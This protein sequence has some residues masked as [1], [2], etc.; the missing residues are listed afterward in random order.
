MPD[1]ASRSRS[2][3]EREPGLSRSSWNFYLKAVS[4]G[5]QRS[6]R[7]FFRWRGPRH[8][9]GVRILFL[10][11]Y[12][13]PETGAPQNRISDWAVRLAARGHEITVLTAMPNYPGGKIFQEYRGRVLCEERRDGI[14]VLRTWIYA[15]QSKDFIPRL[16]NYFSF[17]VSSVLLGIFKT[18]RQDVI[19]VES[20]PLFTGISGLVL[21]VLLR[22]KLVFN[23]SDLWPESAVALGVLKNRLL[24][25]L[26]TW[27]ENLLYRKSALIT[28]QTNGIV[29]KIATRF[30]QKQV[31]LITN[32]IDT[33]FFKS[34]SVERARDARQ[35]VN[36]N[37]GFVVGYAGL[38]GLAQ[39]LETVLDAANQLKQ[40]SDISFAFFGDGP[41]K[42][43]LERLACDMALDNVRFYPNQSRSMVP[44][45]LA[46]FDASV[47]PLRR[48]T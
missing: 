18:G 3:R 2:S 36:I 12:Y 47:V 38:H 34:T 31:E 46:T 23:V 1:Q 37:N 35:K 33:E 41:E 10:T 11:Q 4:R 14:R 26:S 17:A 9:L 7:K 21:R 24:I 5:Q 30:P 39:G 25:T 29:S 43:R 8:D 42:P 40:Y 6:T 13:P 19:V 32:G 16:M 22:A 45:V 48:L 28:G 27:L 20:P 44:E 15:T